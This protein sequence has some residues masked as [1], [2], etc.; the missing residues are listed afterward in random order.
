MFGPLRPV[1]SQGT[2]GTG[3]VA[4]GGKRAMSRQNVAGKITIR[5]P[6][7]VALDL[8]AI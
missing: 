3:L 5:G 6:L 2:T 8:A 4:N 7:P 1:G